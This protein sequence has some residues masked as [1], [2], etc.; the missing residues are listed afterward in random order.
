MQV[1]REPKN[2]RAMLEAL[3]QELEISVYNCPDCGHVEDIKTFD[4]AYMLRDYLAAHPVTT[5]CQIESAVAS[6]ECG[7]VPDEQNAVITDDALFNAA[8][9]AWSTQT[10]CRWSSAGLSAAITAVRDMLVGSQEGK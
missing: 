2:D 10:D 1:T 7:S 6:H 9:E 4:A 3:H 5:P 8:T